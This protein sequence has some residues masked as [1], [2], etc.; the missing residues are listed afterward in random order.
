MGLDFNFDLIHMANEDPLQLYVEAYPEVT[1]IPFYNLLYIIHTMEMRDDEVENLLQRF[2][3]NFPNAE[4]RRVNF[5]V[6]VLIRFNEYLDTNDL[7]RFIVDLIFRDTDTPEPV[8]R[9][10][11]DIPH[12]DNIDMSRMVIF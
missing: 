6:E 11:T 10:R 8:I 4:Y 2:L 12:Y 3:H 5:D 1:E 9:T 7:V